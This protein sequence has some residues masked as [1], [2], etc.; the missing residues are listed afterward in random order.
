M[1]LRRVP[2][3]SI[4]VPEH[5]VTARFDPEE[6]EQFKSS[7]KEVGAIAPV[8]CIEIDNELVLVDGLHRVIEARNAGEKVINVAVMPGD[9]VDVYTK[10]LFL[11]HMRGKPPISEMV[12]LIEFLTKDLKLDSETIAAKTGYNRD[13]IEKLQRLGEL[14]PACRAALDEGKIKVGQAS[15]LL[16]IGD[17]ITQETVMHQCELYGWTVPVLKD[18]IADVLEIQ[19]QKEEEPPPGEPPGPIL[20]ECDFCHQ[21]Y[22]LGEIANPKTCRGCAGIMYAAIATAAAEAKA[23]QEPPKE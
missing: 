10:N 19:R 9:E 7:I 13:Y 15:E 18:Y 12:N 14:T 22:P 8:I 23:A 4:K 17:P 6:Y 1:K 3:D 16:R 2:P 11:D 21:K 20:L 5:R